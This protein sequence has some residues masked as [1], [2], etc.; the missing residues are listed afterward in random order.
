MR[1]CVLAL[2]GV[3]A[4]CSAIAAQN[5]ETDPMQCWWRTS[6]G[7]IRV[8]EPFSLVLTC[9]VVEN[10]AAKVVVDQSKLE[11]SVIQLAP[12]EVTGGSHGADLR[13][14]ERRFFQYEYR[15]RLIAENLFGRDVP[16][17]E[18][19]LS[20]HVQSQTSQR[21][22]IQGRDQSY[23]LPSQ[24][25]RVM[26]MVPTDA[27]DI[28]DTTTETFADVDERSF[29]ANL[30][31]VIGGVL[32][33]LAGLMAL[34]AIVRLVNRFRK[35]AAATD[36]LVSDSAILSAASRELNAVKRAREDGGWTPEL[37]GRAL[38]ALR[39]AAAYALGQNVGQSTVGSLQLT[40]GSHHAQAGNIIVQTGWP[41]GKRIA[42]SGSITPQAVARERA[43]ADAGGRRAAML[44]SLE[45][46]LTCFTAAQYGRGTDL[47][48]A[49]L[50]E[51]LAA[52]SRA[53]RRVKLEQLSLMK[54]FTRRRVATEVENR[55]W[56]R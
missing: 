56:S 6:A 10:D 12:F 52:G 22:A 45:Q 24:S 33:A 7:A 4:A 8:G 34:L 11:P 21:S 47:D 35:P 27:S 25:I 37:A 31:I 49:A 5:V 30:L 1:R 44:E 2:W 16:L 40:D 36:R 23:V 14:D 55:A 29:R 38:G 13:T 15:L 42:V 19:K 20:Y 46:A 9:A 41:K 54:R 26:S 3:G 43:R 53:V 32:F 18:T 51:S 50:D 48:A 17:P 28:R 39:V